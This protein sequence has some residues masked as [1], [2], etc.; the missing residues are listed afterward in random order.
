[1]KGRNSYLGRHPRILA[2]DLTAG[3]R[4]P[5]RLLPAAGSRCHEISVAECDEPSPVCCNRD[6]SRG[7][8]VAATRGTGPEVRS[9]RPGAAQGSCRAAARRG[10]K[11]RAPWE[12][13][14]ISAGE[15]SPTW[16]DW[17][18][19]LARRW[20]KRRRWSSSMAGSRSP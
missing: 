20:P 6:F 2:A 17:S 19:S 14:R 3:K 16:C 13:A 8:C 5:R 11:P 15:S 1:M 18:L 10:K 4:R 7:T 12:I 9:A